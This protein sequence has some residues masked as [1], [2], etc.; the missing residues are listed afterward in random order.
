MLLVVYAL[1]KNYDSHQLYNHLQI[2]EGICAVLAADAVATGE[3]IYYSSIVRRFAE[4]ISHGYCS[5]MTRWLARMSLPFMPCRH[6]RQRDNI[7]WF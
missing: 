4:R 2:G 6:P 5:A 7:K 1:F 3:V